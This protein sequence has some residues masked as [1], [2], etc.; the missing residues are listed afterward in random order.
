MFEKQKLINIQKQ[1]KLLKDK[2]KKSDETIYFF[3]SDKLEENY[4]FIPFII[5]L[6]KNNI[7]IQII[8]KNENFLI[9]NFYTYF[10]IDEFI[11]LKSQKNFILF[12]NPLNLLNF[13][14]LIKDKLFKI[15]KNSILSTTLKNLRV[16][17]LN[18]FH[19]NHLYLYFLNLI[20]SLFFFNIIH[21][22]FMKNNPSF[23]FCVDKGYMPESIFYFYFLKK[24]KLTFTINTGH[25]NNK[26]VLK[27]FD[28]NNFNDHPI[29]ID[30]YNWNKIKNNNLSDEHKS[31]L[32]NEIDYCYNSGLWYNEVGTQ[33]FSQNN[34]K[35]LRENF[36]DNNNPI[37]V[38]FPH[39]LWDGTF[40]WGEDIYETYKD[41]LINTYQLCGKN[42]HINWLF[43]IH[44]GNIV[45]NNRI[46]KKNNISAEEYELSYLTKFNNIKLIKPNSKYSSNDLLKIAKYCITVRG[47]IGLEAAARGLITITGGTGR[48]DN[49]GFT[50]DPKNKEEYKKIMSNIHELEDP[51]LNS[52]NLAQNFLYFLFFKRTLDTELIN[53]RYL[54]DDTAT[55]KIKI[56]DNLNNNNLFDFKEI[57][58]I[59]KWIRNNNKDYINY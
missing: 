34:V 30:I 18:Y 47:T 4:L 10:Y 5:S 20:K 9:K 37:G 45:K 25:Q 24:N 42:N 54:M 16:G 53:F 1:V 49:R 59:T 58:N 55:L 14:Y 36:F 2:N 32:F 29:S 40:F 12:L 13:I 39:I 28:I 56:S 33:H 48:Y 31:K 15:I 23:L 43:K 6:I 22:N 50:I 21:N 35:I 26:L 3:A 52:T 41:W 8:M 57:I 38:V 17:K 46:G 27:K 7:K 51:K 44:P 11:Y 19:P